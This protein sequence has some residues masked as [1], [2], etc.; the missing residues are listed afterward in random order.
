MFSKFNFTSASVFTFQYFT[1]LRAFEIYSGTSWILCLPL[2]RFQCHN[3]NQTDFQAWSWPQLHSI[4]PYLAAQRNKYQWSWWKLDHLYRSSWYL[5]RFWP[6]EVFFFMI[7]CN[8][9]TDGWYLGEVMMR[10]QRDRRDLCVF[11]GDIG[12]CWLDVWY[13]ELSEKKKWIMKQ[14]DLR[15]RERRNV[16]ALRRITGTS[17]L[18]L[19]FR[20]NRI[21]IK[22]R[23]VL[24]VLW[25]YKLSWRWS[26]KESMKQIK[27]I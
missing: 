26:R 23:C 8:Y 1:C 16:R 10:T 4:F 27:Y 15:W 22:S 5:G 9:W 11:G 14:R 13:W 25:Y 2:Y 19:W 17:I 3:F 6:K 12:I 20:I 21:N 24:A 7:C 18:S